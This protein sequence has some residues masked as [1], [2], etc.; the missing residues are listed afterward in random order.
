M[1]KIKHIA[2]TTGDPDKVAAF[3]KEVF[4]MEEVGRSGDT[5]VYL[6]DG[7]LNLT[8]RTCKDND[9]VDVGEQGAGFSGIHHIGFLVEDVE[10]FVAK[11]QNSGGTR[12]T[13]PMT[14]RVESGYTPGPSDV[15]AK[16]TGP[17]GVVIDVSTTGWLGIST[18]SEMASTLP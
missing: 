9:A 10:G 18:G 12:L 13:P 15:E 2:L 4:G 8:I 3:Y 16:V 7:D 17:D 14:D 5:H 11:V 1:P 6:S